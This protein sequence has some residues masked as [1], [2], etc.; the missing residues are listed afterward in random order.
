L[1]ELESVLLFQQTSTLNFTL[2]NWTTLLGSITFDSNQQRSFTYSFIGRQCNGSW[3]ILKTITSTFTSVD[4]ISN[5]CFNYPNGD[6][7]TAD[8]SGKLMFMNNV[9]KKK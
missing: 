8:N 1:S 9:F 3:T 2:T 4:I 5:S 7:S 6:T